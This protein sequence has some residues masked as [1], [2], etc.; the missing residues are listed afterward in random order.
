[1]DAV[2]IDRAMRLEDRNW[3]HRER[4]ALLARRLR[5]LG[6]PGRAVDLGAAGGGNTRVLVDHGWQALAV[7]CSEA[8]VDHAR[9]RGV[10]AM[11]GDIRNL[12]LPSDEFDLVVAFDVL[13]YVDD[14]ASAATE[15]NRMLRSGGTALIAVPSDMRLWSARDVALGRERRYTRDSLSMLLLDAGLTIERMWSWN[16]LLRPVVRWQGR[17]AAGYG[18]E[19]PSPLVNGVLGA[20]V[21][22]ERILPVGRLPGISL[23]AEARSH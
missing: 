13:E 22:S 9:S 23:M 12:P 10:D 1:M 5:R 8:A 18:L 3:W 21:W 7:D 14:D 15:I 11:W 19:E 2:E 4:R 6:T 20:V 16:V 17:K